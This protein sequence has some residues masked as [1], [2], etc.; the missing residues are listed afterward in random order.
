MYRLASRWSGSPLGAALAGLGYEVQ[1]LSTAVV[2]SVTGTLANVV[3]RPTLDA[4]WNLT[5]SNWYDGAASTGLYAQGAI[6]T[7]DA[8]GA[9]QILKDAHL[10]R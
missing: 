2:L 4:D 1:Y 6:V 3:W 8:W 5:S 9:Y 7:F 10:G